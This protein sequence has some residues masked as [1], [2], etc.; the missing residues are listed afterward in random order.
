MQTWVV[1]QPT[2]I[3]KIRGSTAVCSQAEWAAMER[4]RPGYH[5]L[6]RDGIASEGEA[7]RLVREAPGGRAIVVP[8]RR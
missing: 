3:G 7:E 5:T 4:A 8:S 2:T 1:Y 6:I